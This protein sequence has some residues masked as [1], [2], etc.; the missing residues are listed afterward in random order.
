[1]KGLLIIFGSLFL[2][3][4]GAHF[5]N[6]NVS[7]A[8]TEQIWESEEKIEWETV[9]KKYGPTKASD[10]FEESLLNKDVNQQHVAAH[11]FGGALYDTLGISAFASCGD[12]FFYG[13]LHEFIGRAGADGGPKAMFELN[14]QCIKNF[15]DNP[16]ICQ[17]GIGHGLVSYLG[18]SEQNL[19][20]ALEVCSDFNDPGGG[21]TAGVFMEY[22]SRNT[23]VGKDGKTAI[24]QI[25]EKD[26]LRPCLNVQ[27]NEQRACAYW[28]PQWWHA[29]D[30]DYKRDEVTFIEIGSRCR[31]F[32]EP[33]LR[34]GCFEGIGV[35]IMPLF[36]LAT[37]E[38]A[39]KLCKDA[40]GG[41]STYLSACVDTALAI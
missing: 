9:I 24:R 8:D 15:V 26:F 18:Y 20:E 33:T 3:L 35:L 21:C 13:C 28:S 10:I 6:W 17:H 32:D 37:E 31:Y 25:I 19:M 4:L 7:I 16:L 5:F 41:D 1:M 27:S 39:R 11:I 2:F 14:D 12:N 29:A 34:L 38:E 36:D 23:L 30:L 40:S 22:N